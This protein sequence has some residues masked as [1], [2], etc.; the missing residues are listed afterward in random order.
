[1]G[2][3]NCPPPV[4]GPGRLPG[5][6][7]ES[8]NA[9]GNRAGFTGR[10]RA[11]TAPKKRWLKPFYADLVRSEAVIAQEERALKYEA[12]N[13]PCSIHIFL[14]QVCHR[15]GGLPHNTKEE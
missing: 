10:S 14:L 4:R 9:T 15:P 5:L 8:G 13:L 12:S 11:I 3:C 2:W 6:S 1:M 7:P